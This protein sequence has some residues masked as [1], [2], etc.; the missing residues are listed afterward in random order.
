MN[1]KVFAKGAAMSG[2]R[3]SFAVIGCFVVLCGSSVA[4]R[5]DDLFPP[6]WRGVEGT[7]VTEFDGWREGGVG[8]FAWFPDYH[9]FQPDPGGTVGPQV[10]LAS[11]STG[12]VL[13]SFH[14][15]QGVLQIPSNESPLR[16][17]AD[18]FDWPSLSKPVRMQF[19][20]HSSGD[21]PDSLTLL[22]NVGVLTV[23]EIYSQDLADGWVFKMFDFEIVPNP[24]H[25]IIDIHFDGGNGTAY[26]DQLVVD[27][28]CAPEPAAMSMLAIGALTLLRRRRR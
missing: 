19:V 26:I 21:A 16:F 4:A 8:P 7:F 15:R 23:P 24:P 6:D 12:V 20:Y 18:N 11:T 9:T 17:W 14:G 25:E 28:H 5:A 1:W 13:D 2:V 27:T 3:V 22:T 10:V